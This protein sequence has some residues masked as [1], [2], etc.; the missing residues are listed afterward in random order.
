LNFHFGRNKTKRADNAALADNYII[1][2]HTVHANEH[3]G[4]YCRPVYDSAMTYMR[5]FPEQH[6]GAGKRM[7]GT[8]L[9][10]IATVLNDDLSPVAP[11]CRAGT[12]INISAYGDVAG[13]SSIW[14]D[15]RRGVY[16]WF[17]AVEFE[18]V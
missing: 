12:Y 16:N 1:H 3:V 14:M 13:Y 7:Y 11:H 10:N 18:N 2:D 5:P 15:E 8:M 17:V 9:L 6:L 4:T